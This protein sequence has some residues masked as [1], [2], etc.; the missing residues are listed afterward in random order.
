MT[1]QSVFEVVA[2]Y[3]QQLGVPFAPHDLRR[4]YAKLALKGGARLEQ[5]QRNL[6]HAS[7]T[8]TED[9]LGVELDLHDAPCDHLGIRLE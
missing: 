6:G 3:S 5:I 2:G 9:Y 4:T 1:A 7:L 8:T